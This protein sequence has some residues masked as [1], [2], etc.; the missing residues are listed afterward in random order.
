MTRIAH[1]TR[2]ALI[3]L[4][5][6]LPFI[7]CAIVL[8]SYLENINSFI[9][10]DFVIYDGYAI[11]NKPISYLIGSYFEYNALFLSFLT[12]VSFAIETCLYNKLAIFYLAINLYEKSYFTNHVYDNE[13]YYIVAIINALIC[14][15]FCCKG[16]KILRS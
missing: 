8:I 1:K 6:S 7:V 13:I 2:I 16:I 10:E 15:F 9:S 3:R 4:G 12:I 11:P 5:K 14:V